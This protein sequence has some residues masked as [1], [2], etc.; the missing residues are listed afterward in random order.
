MARTWSPANP[1]SRRDQLRKDVVTEGRPRS[2]KGCRH[3]CLGSEVVHL[4]RPCCAGHIPDTCVVTEVAGQDALSRLLRVR[5][6]VSRVLDAHNLDVCRIQQVGT[7]MLPN[8][9]TRSC[10]QCPQ[11][12]TP[13]AAVIIL[14]G[15]P[16]TTISW[17]QSIGY[18]AN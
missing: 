14:D 15:G 2:R 17:L 16:A 8:E 10:D 13:L 3:R 12:A 1:Q 5:G 4:I 9:S 6:S 18:N 11:L 7:E